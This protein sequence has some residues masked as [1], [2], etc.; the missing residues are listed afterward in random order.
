MKC[1]WI[2]VN[3]LTGIKIRCPSPPVK[4][5]KLKTSIGIEEKRLCEKH[6]GNANVL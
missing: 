1:D 5:L 3:N 6:L 4:W 2:I